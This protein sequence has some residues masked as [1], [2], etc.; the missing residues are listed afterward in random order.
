MAIFC[1]RH[2]IA[3]KWPEAVAQTGFTLRGLTNFL[4]RSLHYTSR[5]YLLIFQWLGSPSECQITIQEVLVEKICKYTKKNSF[6][7]VEL[8]EKVIFLMGNEVK[9]SLKSIV[10]VITTII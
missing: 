8:N 3:P 9:T 4:A 5:T 7:P 6:L 2:K 10:H 1:L